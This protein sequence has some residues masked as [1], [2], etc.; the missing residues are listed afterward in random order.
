MSE[1]DPVKGDDADQSRNEINR[2]NE[3]LVGATLLQPVT[4]DRDE[5]CG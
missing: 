1:S 3:K 5:K 2:N 4:E